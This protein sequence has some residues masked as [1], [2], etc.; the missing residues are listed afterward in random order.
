MEVGR[1]TRPLRRDSSR[2][3]YPVD[4]NSQAAPKANYGHHEEERDPISASEHDS[5]D[6]EKGSSP[7]DESPEYRQY[8]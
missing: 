1:G 3:E 5:C 6:H 7:D 8:M 2:R 4:R